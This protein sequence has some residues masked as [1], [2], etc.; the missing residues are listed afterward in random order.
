MRLGRYRDPA[1]RVPRMP[2]SNALRVVRIPS[3]RFSITI[4]V[5]RPAL[6]TRLASANAAAAAPLRFKICAIS[7]DSPIWAAADRGFDVRCR[8][9]ACCRER[10]CFAASHVRQEPRGVELVSALVAALAATAPTTEQRRTGDRRGFGQRPR[11]TCLAM[12]LAR[13]WPRPRRHATGWVH[14]G[15][16]PRDDGP[17]MRLPNENA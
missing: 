11:L 10:S 13:R 16:W 17:A 5:P 6:N 14:L 2:S 12:S 15:R 1:S 3:A 4:S 9:D 7:D 8:G